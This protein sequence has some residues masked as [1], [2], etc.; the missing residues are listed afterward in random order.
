[1]IGFSPKVI[2]RRRIA[3]GL[4]VL[5]LLASYFLFRYLSWPKDSSF[6]V[7]LGTA[8]FCLSSFVG[9]LAFI[10]FFTRKKN[11]YL[12]IGSGFLAV[13][14][15]EG[16]S[17]FVSLQIG[18]SL[19]TASRILLSAFLL[20]SLKGWR[21][22]EGEQKGMKP[23]VYISAAASALLIILA[24]TLLPSFNPYWNF[25]FLTR[26]LELP[27]AILF[28]LAAFA[29]WQK[30]YWKFKFFEFWFVLSLLAAFFAQFYM[31]LSWDYFDAMFNAGYI[32]KIASY[33]LA[34]IGLM[35]ST[36]A[37]FKEVEAEKKIHQGYTKGEYY[38]KEQK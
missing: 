32:L 15:L 11:K 19:W 8:S 36:F 34:L 30:H 22:G 6:Q 10:K 35:M 13:A 3:I 14:I 12:F 9:V 28:G 18:A 33:I 4:L 17:L 25:L 24:V 7:M 31:S 16:Y 37:A 20:L 26:P 2:A 23:R 38:L 29:Y 27:A 1:M 21:E 5:T